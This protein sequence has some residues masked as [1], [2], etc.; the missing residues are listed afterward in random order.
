M[1]NSLSL[2]WRRF[3][4]RWLYPAISLVVAIAVLLSV[5][6]RLQA[7]SITDLIFQGVQIIQLSNL[8][9][10]QEVEIG[11]QMNA[12]LTSREFR[13]YNNPTLNAFVNQAGQR[14]VP[15]SDRPNIP[16][17]FQVVADQNVNAFAT[18]GGFVYITTGLLRL[19]DNEAQV[20]SVLGHE[21][22]HIAGR[23]LVEQ[24]KQVAI[25]RGVANVAGI[26]QS[27][28]VGI[29]VELALNRPN[30]RQAEYDADQRG[31]RTMSGAGYAPS[32]MV[33][34][35]E[36]LLKGSSGT[37]EFLSTHPDTGNRISAL[38]SKINPSTANRGDGLN[39]STYTS[40]VKSLL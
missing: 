3:H 9:D 14:L 36:K 2:F 4:R 12:E 10:Q 24:L 19:A 35:M 21:I 15:K 26:D 27:E 17:T 1:L 33:S 38:K 32:A 16:Y 23:H 8:S 37:P 34:F 40:R 20:A 7:I 29:G 6:L 11:K 28:L 31:L 5:P 18:M 30:S 39:S 22:G 25:Q 13:I